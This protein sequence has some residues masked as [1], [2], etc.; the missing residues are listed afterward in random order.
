MQG[1]VL[2]E[3]FQAVQANQ[4]TP[5]LVRASRMPSCAPS[6]RHLTVPPA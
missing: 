2:S 4:D 5:P 3:S 6:W 1:C